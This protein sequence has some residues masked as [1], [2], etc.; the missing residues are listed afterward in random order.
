M[1]FHAHQR[2]PSQEQL[3][4]TAWRHVGQHQ[5]SRGHKWLPLP[6][7]AP[8]VEGSLFRFAKSDRIGLE[9]ADLL[10]K[11]LYEDDC[12]NIADKRRQVLHCLAR[13]PT[14]DAKEYTQLKLELGGL[15]A[16]VGKKIKEIYDSTGYKAYLPEYFAKF[17]VLDE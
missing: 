7:K 8:A 1:E 16:N 6:A 2:G 5:E 14:P 9:V 4:G 15:M 12:N 11:A 13:S 3:F 17:P 10:L